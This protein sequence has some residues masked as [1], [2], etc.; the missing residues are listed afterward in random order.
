[1][2]YEY[3]E[4]LLNQVY[5]YSY[6]LQ[7][8]N[9][10]DIIIMDNKK[11][12]PDGSKITKT[13]LKNIFTK[14]LRNKCY[15]QIV[16]PS[17][18]LTWLCYEVDNNLTYFTLFNTDKKVLR[19]LFNDYNK[20]PIE[21][22]NNYSFEYF[23][24]NI[25]IYKEGKKLSNYVLL[26]EDKSIFD[27]KK[28]EFV[29]KSHELPCYTS[30]IKIPDKDISWDLELLERVFKNMYL[31]EYDY[32]SFLAFILCLFDKSKVKQSIF[33]NIDKSGV[34]KTSRIIPLIEI[35]LN[36]IVDSNL[37]KKTELYN[38]ANSN[39]IICNEIQNNN[40]NASNLNNIADNNPLTVSRKSDFS[41]EINKED[42]PLIVLMGENLPLFNDLS[43]GSARR[44]YLVPLVNIHYLEFMNKKENKNILNTFYNLLNNN[45]YTVIMFYI[46]QIKK[47]NLLNQD[48]FNKAID[49]MDTNINALREL[50]I[51]EGIIFNKYFIA[52][53]ISKNELSGYNNKYYCI[54]VN[55]SLN[56][57]LEYIENKEFTSNKVID[58]S[59]RKKQL[60]KWIKDLNELKNIKEYGYTTI[61]SG[62][63][64]EYIYYAIALTDYSLSVI[65]KMDNKLLI[66]DM[67]T[68]F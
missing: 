35:G 10:H 16:N 45:P 63:K 42:K 26:L 66:K 52:Y 53:P 27:N 23:L 33:I 60:F 37:L 40:I 46:H 54:G 68:I 9:S 19:G 28:L 8:L 49:N 30:D 14:E 39:A 36:K 65:S 58:I 21:F 51:S 31:H 18:N 55:D 32:I 34:G 12:L 29:N 25:P 61:Q 59:I 3:K 15:L 17:N 20:Y 47:Y 5:N 56:K 50:I 13:Y 41:I 22:V 24:N 6:Q 48:I 62:K 2:E 7:E 43:E 38:I 44:F 1:M 67:N 64:R 57:L 4:N 11:L